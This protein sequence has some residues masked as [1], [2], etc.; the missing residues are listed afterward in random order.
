MAFDM[1]AGKHTE[2]DYFTIVEFAKELPF[3]VANSHKV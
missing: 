2:Q 1:E 3:T